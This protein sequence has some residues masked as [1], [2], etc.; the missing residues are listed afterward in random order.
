MNA[1]RIEKQ[2][3]S[4]VLPE[5]IPLIGKQVEIIVLERGGKSEN[6]TG[7]HAGSAKGKVTISDDF[8]A[9]LVDFDES[10]K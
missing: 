3:D 4:H 7:P 10:L 5:L 6:G 8:D 2:L 9:P 1:I